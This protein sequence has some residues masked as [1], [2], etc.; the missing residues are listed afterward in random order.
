MGVAPE[1]FGIEGVLKKN[2]S[3]KLKKEYGY[4]LNIYGIATLSVMLGEQ[5]CYDY[6]DKSGFRNIQITVLNALFSSAVIDICRI[7]GG[8]DSVK[9][10]EFLKKYNIKFGTKHRLRTDKKLLKKL[11]NRRNKCVAH[12]DKG[13]LERDL[14]EDYPVSVSELRK[15]LEDIGDTLL[16]LYETIYG[17][18]LENI[19]FENGRWKFGPAESLVKEYNLYKQEIRRHNQM[20]DFMK[21]NCKYDLIKIIYNEGEENNGQP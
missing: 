1:N 6:D 8:K 18:P 11:A 5:L 19:R 21:R 12:L 20:V 13:N 10:T 2:M 3:D 4:L 14:T 15:I 7:I 16:P 17:H 9:I